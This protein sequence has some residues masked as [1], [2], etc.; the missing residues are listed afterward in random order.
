LGAIPGSRLAGRILRRLS[1]D[2]SAWLV[3]RHDYY[4][5]SALSRPR[6]A[7]QNMV[8]ADADTRMVA[9]WLSRGTANNSAT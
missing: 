4:A 7:T 6:M 3:R 8:Q 9:Q 2:L 5:H 1:P